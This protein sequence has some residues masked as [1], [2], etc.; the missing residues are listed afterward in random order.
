MATARLLETKDLAL[1]L[2]LFAFARQSFADAPGSID[3]EW[4]APSDCPGRAAVISEV[5]RVLSAAPTR[6]AR[7]RVEGKASRV[8]PDAWHVDLLL[9]GPDWEAKRALDGSTC[10]AVTE[11]ASLVIALAMN[12][13]VEPPPPTKLEPVPE[14]RESPPPRASFQGPA[15]GLA[16]A[17]D[18]ALLPGGTIG[19]EGN[20]AWTVGPIRLELA[21]SYFAERR[22]TLATQNDVG[23]RFRLGAMNARGCYLARVAHAAL[24]PCVDIGVAWTR[25]E[26][27]GPIQT[28]Q[29]SSTTPILG[30]A[31]FA[32]WQIARFFAPFMRFGASTPLSRPE[33]AIEALGHV[34]RAPPVV[35]RAAVGIEMHFD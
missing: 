24:G 6:S 20:L 30:G 35:V 5:D 18:A 14:P 27:F 34:H 7:M 25:A 17:A 1:A 28:Y 29:A 22:A 10:A 15:L 3:L 4:D 9:R 12:P 2:A 33:Y 8:T 11:A 32:E 13:E 21:G 31:A 26:G 23:A 16:A 19:G